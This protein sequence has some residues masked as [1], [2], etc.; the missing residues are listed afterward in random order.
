MAVR[1]ALLLAV[2]GLLVPDDQLDVALAPDED[3]F[4][5]SDIQTSVDGTEDGRYRFSSGWHLRHLELWTEVLG[6]LR[7]QPNLRYLEVGVF[8]GRSLVWMLE[9]VL[10]HPTSRATAIDVF[11]GDYEEVFDANM[12]ASGVADKVTKLVGPSAQELRKLSGAEYHVIYIDGSHTADDVLLDAALSWDLLAPGG[13]LIFDDYAWEGRRGSAPLPEELRPQ[14][15]ID[16]FVTANRYSLELVHR[17][18]QLIVRKRENPCAPKDYCT[19]IGQYNYFWRARELWTRTGAN[20]ELAPAQLDLV[21]QI[22]RSR[23]PGEVDIRLP[24]ELAARE[25]VQALL[26]ELEI[27]L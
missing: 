8:E 27:D 18:Y 22:A 19:P 15:A 17:G 14:L 24:P 2:V 5:V 13:V 7:G 12:E 25:D 21:E 16:A 10:T 3:H 20:I 6:D 9:N 26:A 1:D 11:A 4:Y 23:P